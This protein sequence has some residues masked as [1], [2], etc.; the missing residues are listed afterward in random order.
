MPAA[1]KALWH[2]GSRLP[3]PSL[4]SKPTGLKREALLCHS[5]VW[6]NDLTS[7]SLSHSKCKKQFHPFLAGSTWELLFTVRLPCAWQCSKLFLCINSLYLHHPPRKQILLLPTFHRE[8]NKT[9]MDRRQH[10]QGTGP[11]TQSCS[12]AGRSRAWGF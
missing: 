1:W 3:R 6:A 8:G 7:V 2:R 5:R 4:A 12:K 10:I 9:E 11:D